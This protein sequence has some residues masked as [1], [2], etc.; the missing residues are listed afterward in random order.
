[1]FSVYLFC[2]IVGGVL[3]LLSLLTGQGDFDSGD[4]GDLDADLDTDTFT[5]WSELPLLSLRFWVFGG[6]MFGITGLIL[7]LTGKPFFTTFIGALLTGLVTGWSLNWILRHLKQRTPNSLITPDDLIGATGTVELPCD[8]THPG[9]VRLTLKGQQVEYPA[10]TR[11]PTPLALG[12]T[13][14]VVDIH[15]QWVE[16]IPQGVDNSETKLLD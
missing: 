9:K 7:T 16:I 4:I 2:A 6:G 1:M 8:P 3:M 11:H 13:I 14:V 5:F 12:E 15:D 10:R